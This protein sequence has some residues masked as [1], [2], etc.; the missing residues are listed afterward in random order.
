M[1][2]AYSKT[3]AGATWRAGA[4]VTFIKAM[5]GALC[6]GLLFLLT[7]CDK[8]PEMTP[9]PTGRD[10][11]CADLTY[12]GFPRQERDKLPTRFLCRS[13]TYALNFDATTRTAQWVA[14]HLTAANLAQH[15]ALRDEDFRPDPEMGVWS[16]KLSDYKG[17][18]MDRGH[19]APAEDFRDDPV[20][21]NT[22]FYLTNMVPQNPDL[23]RGLWSHLEQW[24]RGMAKRR[25]ELWVTTGPLFYEAR[26][27]GWVGGKAPGAFK[28]QGDL[29]TE[30]PVAVPTHIYKVIIDPKS[31]E[32]WAFIIP[33]S[34]VPGPLSRYLVP[35]ATVESAT[36]L[37]FFPDLS[38]DQQGRIKTTVPRFDDW[39]DK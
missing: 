36:G 17:S 24:T 14:E 34:N 31:G 15:L 13:Q 22:S 19:L 1:R 6:C 16:P 10:A 21:M 18:T 30:R 27:L 3:A 7:G 12:A 33:N 32:A 38:M 39:D 5:R 28:G 23:N 29:G 37:R 25:G 9:V 26:V 20:K 8:P 35:V 11:P 4:G 2:A